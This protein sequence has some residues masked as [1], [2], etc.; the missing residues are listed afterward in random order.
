MCRTHCDRESGCKSRLM[1]LFSSSVPSRRAILTRPLA[2]R[3]ERGQERLCR[4]GCYH[5]R[6]SL[7]L[8]DSRSIHLLIS[9]S[10]SQRSPARLCP[11]ST[12]SAMSPPPSRPVASVVR[13]FANSVTSTHPFSSSPLIIRRSRKKAARERRVRRCHRVG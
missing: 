13:S 10:H 7:H 2:R 4:H 8:V 11:R 9:N 6:T 3:A 5:V 12:H 1:T